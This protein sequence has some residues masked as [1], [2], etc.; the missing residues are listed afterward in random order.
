MCV[1]Q[2]FE[3]VPQRHAKQKHSSGDRWALPSMAALCVRDFC[4]IMW[5]AACSCEWCMVFGCCGDAAF[6][7]ALHV[8]PLGCGASSLCG[9]LCVTRRKAKRR[10][11][12]QACKL[13]RIRCARPTARS[14]HARAHSRTTHTYAAHTPAPAHQHP[15]PHPHDTAAP[16]QHETTGTP[17]PQRTPHEHDLWLISP[18]PATARAALHPSPCSGAALAPTAVPTSAAAPPAA[19]P[20]DAMRASHHV[21]GCTATA[22][23]ASPAA[24][25]IATGA[26]AGAVPAARTLTWRER[27]CCAMPSTPASAAFA[28]KLA[29]RAVLLSLL[30]DRPA[31]DY[32]CITHPL[33]ASSIKAAACGTDKA[34]EAGLSTCARLPPRILHRTGCAAP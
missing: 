1:L 29:A 16:G 27:S 3:G 13:T 12:P 31:V 17:A 21:S 26:G 32:S 10:A 33:A 8:G 14:A 25:P 6:E 19:A 18:Y 24:T 23:A 4:I 11:L 34:A 28:S 5:S 9:C 20:A 30:P 15:H 2:K 7:S 22:A